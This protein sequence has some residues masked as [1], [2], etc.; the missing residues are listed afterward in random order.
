MPLQEVKPDR[1]YSQKP[2][3]M[4]EPR[5]DYCL[6]TEPVVA[7]GMTAVEAVDERYRLINLQD[8]Q[9]TL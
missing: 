7:A 6:A 8:R 4:P 1:G 3:L 5:K 9:K 2:G